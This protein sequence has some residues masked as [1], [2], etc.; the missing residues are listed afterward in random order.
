MLTSHNSMVPGIGNYDVYG[1]SPLFQLDALLGS[2]AA[3]NEMLV[4]RTTDGVIRVFPAVP[5]RRS[6]S[7]EALRVPGAVLVSAARNEADVEWV[8]IRPERNGELAFACPWPEGAG[9]AD[10]PDVR[11]SEDGTTF[12]WTGKAQATYRFVPRS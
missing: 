1:G 7:F 3:L 5:G 4:Q 12:R 11:L 6:A 2:V 10:C 9:I 8:A